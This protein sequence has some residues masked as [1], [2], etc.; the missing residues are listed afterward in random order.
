[1]DAD[2]TLGSS[3]IIS[4]RVAPGKGGSV[5]DSS[6]RSSSWHKTSVRLPLQRGRLNILT[7]YGSV[8]TCERQDMVHVVSPDGQVLKNK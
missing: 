6:L 4:Q 7:G 3:S 1:M 2:V 5:V 8:G